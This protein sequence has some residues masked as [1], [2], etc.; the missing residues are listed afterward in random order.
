VPS[1][2]PAR[3]AT[4]GS[5]P[6]LSILLLPSSILISASLTP[7]AGGSTRDGSVENSVEGD[8]VDG[9]RRGSDGENSATDLATRHEEAAG[10]GHGGREE[11]D[12]AG[13]VEQPGGDQEARRK[14]ERRKEDNRKS[15]QRTRERQVNVLL[16]ASYRFPESFLLHRFLKWARTRA[17]EHTSCRGT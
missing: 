15:A 10:S 1:S 4:T 2:P 3:G 6:R 17:L 7:S 8:S 9:R 16:R 14:Q 12:T 13:G 11:E 5:S